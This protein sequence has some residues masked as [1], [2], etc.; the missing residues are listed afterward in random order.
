M[1]GA[2][3]NIEPICTKVGLAILISER[4]C[5]M[6]RGQ[7]FYGQKKNITLRSNKIFKTYLCL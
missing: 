4:M 1:D 5:F 3:V 2:A 7:K 6:F